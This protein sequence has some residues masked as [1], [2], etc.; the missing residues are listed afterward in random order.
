MI[1]FD[2]EL[3]FLINEDILG[4]CFRSSPSLANP[5]SLSLT[6]DYECPQLALSIISSQGESPKC[7]RAQRMSDILQPGMQLDFPLFKHGLVSPSGA[8]ELSVGGAVQN[9]EVRGIEVA[10]TAAAM[11]LKSSDG[12]EAHQLVGGVSQCFMHPNCRDI[13]VKYL[14]NRFTPTRFPLFVS[15]GAAF[16]VLIVGGDV[17]KG[18]LEESRQS[19]QTPLVAFES[20]CSLA[21]Q[22]PNLKQETN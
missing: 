19:I 18:K 6:V 14:N 21:A 11:A 20:S 16:R 22:P 10:D 7:R 4:K 15:P 3:L 17:Q 12:C 2:P 1:V 13:A 5:I 8:S 9:G